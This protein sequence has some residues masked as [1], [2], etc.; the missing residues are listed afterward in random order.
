MPTLENDANFSPAPQHAA[1]ANGGQSI[2]VRNTP[3]EVLRILPDIVK[4]QN[5][6]PSLLPLISARQVDSGCVGRFAVPST[7]VVTTS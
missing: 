4:T 1:R 6:W 3:A 7:C 2:N 5:K